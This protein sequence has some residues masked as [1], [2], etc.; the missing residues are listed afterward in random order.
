MIVVHRALINTIAE[1]AG[2]IVKQLFGIVVGIMLAR[3]LGPSD[4]G[5]YSFAISFSFIFMV[6][7]DFGMN[8]LYVRDIA[9]DRNLSSKYLAASLIVKP[10]LCCIS[11]CILYL[12]LVLLKY[13]DEI[14]LCTI[15]FS[16]HIFFITQINTIASIFLSFERIE[17]NTY[18][19]IA[20]GIITLLLVTIVVMLKLSVITIILSRVVAFLIIFIISLYLVIKYVSKPDFKIN[21]LYIYKIA[22]RAFP[23]LAVSLINTLYLMID[24]I[25]LSKMKGDE[26]VGW[27]A[28]AANDLFFGLFIIPG[29]IATVVYPIFSRHF[30][31][32]LDK[33][34][35]SINFT[36]KILIVLGVPI[37]VGTLVLAPQIINFF[38]GPKYI[39]SVIVLQLMALAISFAFIREPLG[40]GIASI[41][42]EKYLMWINAFFLLLKIFLN[43][44]FIRLY[45]HV[46]AAITSVFCIIFSMFVSY[47]VLKSKIKDLFMLNHFVKPSA[48]A[49]LMGVVI[50][51]LRDINIILNILVGAI[52]YALAIFL[53]D[54]FTV[55]EITMLKSIVKKQ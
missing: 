3:Y 47:F 18:L 12:T 16:G 21:L 19:S 13:S 31:Q 42:K 51:L 52:L 43:L 17:Y 53:I 25:M 26:V 32:S 24:V 41:G 10:M 48:A 4:Y 54:T 50:F 33:L 39:N 11:I 40:F 7:S 9:F 14:I 22:K 23:F 1:F 6:L 36:I 34:K 2:R 46:G 44:I 29:T 5:K 35:E 8:D 49:F 30:S 27:Y 15:I 37:S 38:F 55:S 45:G 20:T 28:P